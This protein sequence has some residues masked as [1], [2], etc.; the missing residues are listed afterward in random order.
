MGLVTTLP[1]SESV[2]MNTV[3]DTGSDKGVSCY[4]LSSCIFQTFFFPEND[5]PPMMADAQVIGSV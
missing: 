4:L 3:T 1:T 2:A 5:E